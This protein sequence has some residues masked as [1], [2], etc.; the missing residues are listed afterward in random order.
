MRP[1]KMVIENKC[2]LKVCH[3][4]TLSFSHFNIYSISKVDN[5]NLRNFLMNNFVLGLD[6]E[7][8]H[9]VY[10]KGFTTFIIV[11]FLTYV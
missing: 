9:S 3:L 10:Q 4:E 7:V 1:I 2:L 11:L 6:Y 8:I 5:M